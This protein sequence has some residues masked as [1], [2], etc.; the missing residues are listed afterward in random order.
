MGGQ[1]FGPLRYQDGRLFTSR[2]LLPQRWITFFLTSLWGADT[3][4]D[5]RS[6]GNDRS[7]TSVDKTRIIS[8]TGI[9][10]SHANSNQQRIRVWFRRV[11]RR[12]QDIE[13][14]RGKRQLISSLPFCESPQSHMTSCVKHD[15]SL[16]SQVSRDKQHWSGNIAFIGG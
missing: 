13:M 16:C 14:L 10:Y 6:R 1:N 5:A 12:E 15:A 9:I 3:T 8:I 4:K 7:E 11:R 2:K